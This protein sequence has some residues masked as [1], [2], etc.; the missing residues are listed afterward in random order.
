MNLKP[1][2]VLSNRLALRRIWMFRV[3]TVILALFSS[4]QVFSQAS[5]SCSIRPVSAAS[6]E[7]ILAKG[8]IETTEVEK[9]RK[10]IPSEKGFKITR[11]T[12][13]IDCDNC[14]IIIREVFSDSFSSDDIK[15]LSQIKS[16][17]VISFECILG[18]NSKG[19]LV[20]YKPFL[21]YVR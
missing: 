5:D 20:A 19:E 6:V 14:E 1:E 13:S 12:Y 17:Q 3:L 18:T 15:L 11:F 9:F 16:R 8:M 7:G 4:L 2:I 10:L 21:F